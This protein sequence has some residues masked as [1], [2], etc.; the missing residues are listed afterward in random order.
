MPPAAPPKPKPPEVELWPC[1][2]LV[3]VK[4]KDQETYE[5]R[6]CGYLPRANG[7]PKLQLLPCGFVGPCACKV[8]P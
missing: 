4:P 8:K 3:Y 6:P 7:G 1:G 5:L 2:R